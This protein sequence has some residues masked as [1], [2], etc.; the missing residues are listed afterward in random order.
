MD[1]PPPAAVELQHRQ[2]PSNGQGKPGLT[3]F[4]RRKVS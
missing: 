3:Q 2:D 4:L 1:T